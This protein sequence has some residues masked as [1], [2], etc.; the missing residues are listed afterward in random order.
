M[1]AG[2]ALP[3]SFLWVPVLKDPAL[4]WGAGVGLWTELPS[5][6]DPFVP[7]GHRLKG[8]QAK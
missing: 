2:R 1:L 7:M 3:S 8:R 4:G 5:Q 6:A